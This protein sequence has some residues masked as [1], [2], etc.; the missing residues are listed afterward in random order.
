MFSQA[1]WSW[2][3]LMVDFKRFFFLSAFALSCIEAIVCM[4]VRDISVSGGWHF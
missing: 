3:R 1:Y 4:C 2:L